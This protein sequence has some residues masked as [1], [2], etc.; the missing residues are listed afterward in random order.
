MRLPAWL[1]LSRAELAVLL[2]LAVLAGTPPLLLVTQARGRVF[3]GADGMYGSGDMLQYMAWVRDAATHWLA[4]NL[5]QS[6]PDRHVFLHPMFVLSGALVRMGLGIQLAYMAWLPAGLVVLFAGTVAFCRRVAL[7][8]AGARVAAI[9]VALFYFSPVAPLLAWAGLAGSADRTSTTAIGAEGFS[10][11]AL[12]GYFP[13]AIALGLMPVTVLL[14]AAAIDRPT[15]AGARGRAWLAAAAA[16][17]VAWLHPWQ[18]LVLLLM[19]L[20]LVAWARFDRRAWAALPAVAGCLAALGYYAVLG[21]VSSAW[22]MT[23]VPNHFPHA[24]FWLIA[25]APLALAALPGVRLRADSALERL[26]LLWVPAAALAYVA[27]NR[28]FFYHALE[29]LSL[30]LGIFAIRGVTRI[31]HGRQVGRVL[32]AGTLVLTVPGTLYALQV[33]LQTYEAGNDYYLE[34]DDA[35]ALDYLAR[36]PA[37]AVLARLSLGQYVP[38]FTGHA[39]WLGNYEWT[40]GFYPRRAQAEDLFEGRLEPAAVS[41]LV[42]A[43]GARYV[44]SGCGDNPKATARLEALATATHRFGCATVYDVA[45]AA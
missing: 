33:Y 6:E 24:G 19:L 38:A 3:N 10:A 11:G 17:L 45:P 42:V 15:E 30:P 28:S 40:P 27:L 12:W 23:A 22:A 39:T 16:L 37:G 31:F 20:A 13:T 7:P 9:V 8:S 4:S 36:Q 14:V 18:G 25:L 21:R 44:L 35:R 43:S 29:G 5:F 41:R 1:R 26:L 2:G 32:V 34:G